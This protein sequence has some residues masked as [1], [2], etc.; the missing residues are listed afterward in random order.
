MS[1]AVLNIER[2]KKADQY[3]K[4]VAARRVSVAAQ[5]LGDSDD[6]PGTIYNRN[7]LKGYST[8]E[9]NFYPVNRQSRVSVTTCLVQFTTET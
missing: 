8:S 1:I 7:L 2:P 6:L 3:D 9:Y 4:Y 5:T